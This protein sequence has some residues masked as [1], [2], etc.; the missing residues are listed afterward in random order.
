MLVEMESG[1][2]GVLVDGDTVGLDIVGFHEVVGAHAVL[3]VVF[4]T[5][6]LVVT[7]VLVVVTGQQFAEAVAVLFH[8]AGL[9][10]LLTEFVVAMVAVGNVLA[11]LGVVVV[12]EGIILVVD[13]LVMVVDAFVLDRGVATVV[14]LLIVGVFSAFVVDGF[15]LVVARLV[16][17]WLLLEDGLKSHAVGGKSIAGSMGLQTKHASSKN[18]SGEVHSCKKLNYYNN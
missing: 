6:L 9:R 15:L 1:V 3:I 11:V 7:A 8:A 13:W 17:D 12:I 14:I 4:A 5:V 2:D 16:M 10:E 18:R